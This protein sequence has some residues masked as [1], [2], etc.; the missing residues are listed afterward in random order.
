M[1]RVWNFEWKVKWDDYER[2]GLWKS[3]QRE[4]AKQHVQPHK[5][6]VSKFSKKRNKWKWKNEKI[7]K[8]ELQGNVPRMDWWVCQWEYL[9]LQ[10][11]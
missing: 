3:N 9:N 5:E 7:G 11:V 4:E 6:V 8:N 10:R 1:L 2:P